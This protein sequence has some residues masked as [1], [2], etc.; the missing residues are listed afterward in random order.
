M[1][2]LT[3]DQ[4]VAHGC[5]ALRDDSRLRAA[6]IGHSV[7]MRARDYFAHNTPD[8]VTPWTRIQAKGYSDPSAENIAMGQ[9]TPQAVVDAWM[10]SPGHRANI[11]SCSSKAIG[12]GV[13]F[14]PNGPWWTQDFGYS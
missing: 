8:G 6:A 10:N 13:Q 11:L 12:V 14:G 3:N 9:A 4:R 1:V 5:P 7:D 2:A